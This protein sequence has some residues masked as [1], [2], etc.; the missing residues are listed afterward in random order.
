M[1]GADEYLGQVQ[2]T[3]SV[4]GVP[5]L[6][7]YDIMRSGSPAGQLLAAFELR[8]VNTTTVSSQVIAHGHLNSR[9]KKMGMGAYTEKPFNV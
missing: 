7:W 3:P 5:R 6:E 8:K 4:K 9:A 1:Q 2:C